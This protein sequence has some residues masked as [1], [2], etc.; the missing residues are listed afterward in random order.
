MR[1]TPHRVPRSLLV[2]AAAA[3][4]VLAACGG[5]TDSD[6][7]EGATVTEEPEAEPQGTATDEPEAEL[8]DAPEGR[9]EDTK[10]TGADD[11]AAAPERQGADPV[12]DEEL[13][14]SDFGLYF[15]EQ[16]AAVDVVG[17][18]DGDVLF[19]R[20]LPDHTAQEVGRLS[21]TGGAVLAGRERSVE[22]GLWAEI[23]LAGGVGWVNSRYLGYLAEPGEDITGAFDQYG[24]QEDAV[25]LVAD[26]AQERVDEHALESETPQWVLIQTPADSPV[27]RVD[28]FPFF[29]DATYGERLEIHVED[30]A[31]GVEVSQVQRTF[32]CSRGVSDG[33]CV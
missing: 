2:A 32:I 8:E 27:Y 22:H 17:V 21:P 3:A 13:P 9:S 7:P 10:G 1:L 28:V 15:S 14:G 20:A 29:D 23:E 31:D 4:L 16:G 30:T 24:G 19:V 33:L 25:G 12:P 6:P 11:D 26:I 5:T 18:P